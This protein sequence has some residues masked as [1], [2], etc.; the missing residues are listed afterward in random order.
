MPPAAVSGG[1]AS[2]SECA[3]TLNGAVIDRNREEMIMP[4][5]LGTGLWILL[6]A[7]CSPSF[8]GAQ[9]DREQAAFDRCD[10]AQAAASDA[11]RTRAEACDD[12]CGST[13]NCAS[14]ECEARILAC[15]ARCPLSCIHESDVLDV[16]LYPIPGDRE[17]AEAEQ[18]A[19]ARAGARATAACRAEV[20]AHPAQGAFDNCVYPVLERQEAEQ[21]RARVAGN[22]TRE[23]LGVCIARGR[24][25]DA[26]IRMIVDERTQDRARIAACRGPDRDECVAGIT[27]DR[28][29]AV[30]AERVAEFARVAAERSAGFV[31]HDATVT[32][33]QSRLEWQRALRPGASDHESAASYCAALT[34]N[35][36]GWRLPTEAELSGIATASYEEPAIDL[37]A[38]PGTPPT[39]FWTSTVDASTEDTSVVN[40]GLPTPG[41]SDGGDTWTSG[42]TEMSSGDAGGAAWVRCV[43]RMRR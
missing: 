27:R 2:T 10:A 22:T 11:A 30:H 31:V 32:D 4:R 17:A 42:W 36:R 41:C 24:S 38:F 26:C 7:T 20:Q 16:C 34:I 9:C 39:Y 43:R 15:E 5:I 14:T 19:R 25:R 1:K 37:R 33:T 6:I 3:G 40:F 18:Q 8:A 23:R 28:E 12:R 13:G 35:G 21:N 29:A